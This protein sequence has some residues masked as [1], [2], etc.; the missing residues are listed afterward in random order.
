MTAQTGMKGRVRRN[1]WLI[2]A[3]VL[4]VLTAAVHLFAGT[5][6]V[7]APLLGA[8]F[9]T[10]VMLELYAVW[11]LVSVAL[12]LTAG[13]L[14]WSAW[15]RREA[16]AGAVRLISAM[17]A[18]FGAVFIGVDLWLAGPSGLLT[19]P[20]WTIL[21]LVGVLGF[22]G[23]NASERRLPLAQTGGEPG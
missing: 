10:L 11:H 18:L 23:A 4:A 16:H 17:W 15:G 3:A 8:G 1:G 9:D 12:A 7:H 22:A 14:V 5:P 19:A 21:L 2:G 13:V 20:Q 6:E